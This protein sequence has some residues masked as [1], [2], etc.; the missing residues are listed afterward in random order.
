V[1]WQRRPTDADLAG[2]VAIIQER[3]AE[4]VALADPAAPPL[5]EPVLPTAADTAMSVYACAVH[6][7]AISS[8]TLVHQSTCTAPNSASG[9]DC[10]PEPP[11]P[12]EEPAVPPAP[13]VLP[14]DW[15][16]T[17]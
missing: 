15:Q 1:Q 8:A 3:Y 11:P 10:T 12:P 5:P 16:T 2:L 17:A 4:L 9:C 14:G 13:P 6:A 7:I